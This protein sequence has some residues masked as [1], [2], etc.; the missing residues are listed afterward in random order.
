MYINESEA[1]AAS[2]DCLA[3]P[4]QNKRWILRPLTTNKEVEIREIM[5][6]TLAH[7]QGHPRIAISLDK[8]GINNEA[9][10]LFDIFINSG[11]LADK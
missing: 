1:V 11:L 9:S 7:I 4:K 10:D 5:K 6:D 2:T 3:K 8:M